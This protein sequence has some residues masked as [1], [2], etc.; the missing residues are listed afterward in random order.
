MF[1]YF[2]VQC[3]V[4]DCKFRNNEEGHEEEGKCQGR[5][6]SGRLII[7]AMGRCGIYE[8]REVKCPNCGTDV[9]VSKLKEEE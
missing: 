7:T 8:E 5:P 9:K 4:E 1:T 6:G 2:V 3:D